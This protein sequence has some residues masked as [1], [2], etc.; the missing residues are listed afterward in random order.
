MKYTLVKRKK[1]TLANSHQDFV[2][3]MRRHDVQHWSSNSTFM[4]GYAH[5][6]SLFENITLRADHENNFVEDLQKN[7]LLLIEKS[8]P[9]I[10]RK[11]FGK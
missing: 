8:E 2:S 4:E 9:K 1:S 3:W 6:K 7:E 5:R 11:L 10:F